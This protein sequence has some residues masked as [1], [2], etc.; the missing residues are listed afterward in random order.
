M[1]CAGPHRTS[2]AQRIDA[3]LHNPMLWLH[4]QLGGAWR[5]ILIATAVVVA[6]QLAMVGLM[7]DDRS[8]ALTFAMQACVGLLTV[9]QFGTLFLHGNLTILRAVSRDAQTRMIESHRLSPISNFSGALGYVIGPNIHTLMFS[10]MLLI[11][12]ACCIAIGDRTLGFMLILQAYAIWLAVMIWSFNALIA[13]SF[14]GSSG[15]KPN[16][17]MVGFALGPLQPA[18]PGIAVILGLAN[19]GQL[20]SRG[21]LG[22]NPAQFALDMLSVLP[23]QAILTAIFIYGCSRK[24]RGQHI[25]SIPVWTGLLLVL[26]LSVACSLGVAWAQQID[27][28]LSGLF[29]FNWTADLLP[30]ERVGVVFGLSILGVGMVGLHPILVAAF[31]RRRDRLARGR[32]DSPVQ[33]PAREALVALAVVALTCGVFGAGMLLQSIYLDVPLTELTLTGR[34]LL[35]AAALLAVLLTC[36]DVG[37]LA[38][39]RRPSC[40]VMLMVWLAISWL[41]PLLVSA[42]LVTAGAEPMLSE[43]ALRFC[44]LVMLPGIWADLPEGRESINIAMTILPIAV[45]FSLAAIVHLLVNLREAAVQRSEQPTGQPLAR[46]VET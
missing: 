14:A 13:L 31:E 6:M 21:P 44:P 26:V 19:L 2:G 27:Q 39:L 11:N 28:Q 12:T 20:I 43:S 15:F 1:L 9:L 18:V 17:F 34:M 30:R 10:G 16:I 45:W 33:P 23:L 36:A 25:P 41:G 7:L 42:V 29:L 3:V 5:R 40:T 4:F 24:F 37:R 35:S 8:S 32:G 22:P 46:P 38:Y